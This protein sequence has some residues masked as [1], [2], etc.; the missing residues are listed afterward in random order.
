MNEDESENAAGGSFVSRLTG[1]LFGRRDETTAA[2]AVTEDPLLDSAIT[3][4][5]TLG[6][7]PTPP[8]Y[9]VFY[10][11][12]SGERPQLSE[13]IQQIKSAGET[14]T[15]AKIAELYERFF[16][17]E[18]EGLAVYEAS[19]NVER[20]LTVVHEALSTAGDTTNSHGERISALHDELKKQDK[21]AEIK[22]VVT[23]ILSETARM[24]M[25]INK[26]ER[27]VVH[28]AAEIAELRDNL[29]QAQREAN[30]DPLTGIANRKMLEYELKRAAKDA[31]EAQKPFSVLMVDVD[32][33]KKFNDD[34]GHQIGDDALKLVARTLE[35]G[36]KRRDLAARFGGE[37]FSVVL[38]ETPLD[39]AIKLAENLRERIE[40][41]KLESEGVTREV[42]P[43]TI[44]VG[45]AQYR[46]E[47]PLKRLIGRADRALPGQGTGPQ[48]GAERTRHRGAR[49]PESKPKARA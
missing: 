7:K 4:M 45:V 38:V 6:V 10:T 16:G 1:A 26:L 48:P 21:V 46:D 43:V 22:K 20:L 32:H 42:R 23:G 39:G 15:A 3:A 11:H 13:E 37:E 44:S 27:R 14:F 33:F 12:V 19:R 18:Q 8:A 29:E 36:I 40:S 17:A 41:V 24:R 28:S 31:A 49:P 25:S 5:R 30:A 35:Q 34:Y 47:E 2:V 9:T